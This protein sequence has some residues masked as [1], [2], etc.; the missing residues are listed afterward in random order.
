MKLHH[1]HYSPTSLQLHS[2]KYFALE[3][4]PILYSRAVRSAGRFPGTPQISTL[5]KEDQPAN[6][7]PL[8]V[9][10]RRAS[11]LLRLFHAF[12]LCSRL[13]TFAMVFSTPL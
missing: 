9:L 2:Y 6:V 3:V 1:H 8:F 10:R 11:L 4:F 5:L 13:K 12:P 7:R